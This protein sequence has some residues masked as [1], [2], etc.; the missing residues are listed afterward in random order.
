MSK[1][2]VIRQL[3]AKGVTE[4]EELSRQAKEEY[5]QD[6]D[7]KAAGVY[8]SQ[9]LAKQRKK[10][11]GEAPTRRRET[12]GTDT[13]TLSDLDRVYALVQEKGNLEALAQQVS[14]V[15]SLAREV[16]GLTKLKECLDHLAKYSK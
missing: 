12:D 15:E 7:R 1:A 13:I 4:P 2:E 5:G 3:L 10:E 8:K 14:E 16:G 6:I 9:E 11:G